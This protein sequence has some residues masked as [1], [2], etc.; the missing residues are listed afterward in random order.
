VIFLASGQ[1]KVN[2][3][4]S[5]LGHGLDEAAV[6]AAKQIRFKPAIRDGQPVDFPARVR[7]SF[8]VAS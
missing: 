6:Q 1:V 7:I 2:G 4:V 8:R 3:V 5:G